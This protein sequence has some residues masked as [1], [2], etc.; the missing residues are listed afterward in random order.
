[1]LLD[2]FTSLAIV[3]C[4]MHLLFTIRLFQCYMHH[5]QSALREEAYQMGV[6]VALGHVN[7]LA[8]E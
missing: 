8:H 1:M 2:C 6:Q 3:S 5:F 4:H 7:K